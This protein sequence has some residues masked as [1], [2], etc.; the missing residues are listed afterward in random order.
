MLNQAVLADPAGTIFSVPELQL[1]LPRNFH[2][3]TLGSNFVQKDAI[4][5]RDTITSNNSSNGE[6]N[7]FGEKNASRY[8]GLDLRKIVVAAY[9]DGNPRT[10]AFE[11]KRTKQM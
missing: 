9:G 5:A 2:E 7:F 11:G 3:E 6:S 4:T 8:S 10:G 1:I